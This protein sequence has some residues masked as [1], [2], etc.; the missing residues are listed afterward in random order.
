MAIF[1]NYIGD[2]RAKAA[3]AYNRYLTQTVPLPRQQS[4][5]AHDSLIVYQNQALRFIDF[6][7]HC[8]ELTN[9]IRLVWK[10]TSTS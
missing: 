2:N 1:G 7:A 6:K 3:P 9:S 8:T 4:M 10:K 5:G